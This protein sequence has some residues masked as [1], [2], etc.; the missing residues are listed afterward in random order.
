MTMLLPTY[1]RN[2]ML[3]FH[4]YKQIVAIILALNFI[5]PCATVLAQD[6]DT[7]PAPKDEKEFNLGDYYD[8][9]DP[10][11]QGGLLGR[12]SVL[13]E[14]SLYFLI[15]AFTVLGVIY[16]LPESVS[17]W[18][19][20]DVNIEHGL[21]NWPEN[22]TNWEWDKD[23]DWINYIGHP[24]FGST[25]Y[26]YA[27]HYGY[28]RLESFWFSFTISS[29]YEIGLEAWA[30]PVSVQDMIF[31]PV[32][33]SLL[34]ELLLPLEHSIKKNDSK[35]LGSSFLG[36]V[37]LVLI[38]PFGHVVPPLKRWFKGNVSSDADIQ[39]MPTFSM[40]DH[41]NGDEEEKGKEYQWGLQL[42]VQW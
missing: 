34:G 35:V 7:N 6:N 3:P 15:P 42:S 13:A 38:D 29:F 21:D 1:S 31:T 28:S 30:E 25:Y 16:I 11:D 24:Y 40:M 5:V 27:R 26:I 8:Q 17:N 2:S 18:E 39:L 36:T 20:D 19:K 37:S 33:G 41:R 23:D 32:L 9:L 10:P 12:Y 22:V 4:Q 14:D